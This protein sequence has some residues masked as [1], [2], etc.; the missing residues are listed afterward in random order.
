MNG[1][2]TTLGGIFGAALLALA[3]FSA[4]GCPGDDSKDNADGGM[5]SGGGLGSVLAKQ[6]GLTC[7]AAGKGVALGNASISGYAPIDGFFRSVVNYSSVSASVSADIDAELSGIQSLFA[8]TDAQLAASGSLGLAITAKL[9]TDFKASVVVNAQ[10]AQCSVDAHVAAEVT[11]KCQA[12]ANC[13]V[14]PGKATFQCM[15]TCNVDAS[16]S[17]SCSADA[18]VHCQVTSPSFTCSGQCSGSCT[19]MTPTVACGGTCRGTC[20][21]MCTGGGTAGTNVMGECTGTC[22]GTCTGGCEVTGMAAAMCKGSCSGTCDYDPG[23][24]MCDASAKVT[25]DLNATASASCTGR[26]SGD[27]QPPSAMCDASASCQA[28]AKAEAR[29]Q[30]HCTPPSVEVKVVSTGGVMAQAQVNFL[31]AELKA[32]LPR[33]SVASA[34]AKL[35]SDAAGDLSASGTAAVQTTANAV[36][37]GKLDFFVGAKVVA[38]VPAQLTEAQ[39]VLTASSAALKTRTDAAAAVAKSFGMVM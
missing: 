18:K 31:I 33:L 21:G 24:A 14:D 39:G 4:S 10:P 38:C 28:S 17:G 3:A 15:G 35:A 37:T 13:T 32:R 36:G 1:R 20:D 12:E 8:I 11:A 25:C 26:C 7:P 30:V 2:T 27:F 34:R 9:A 23:M 16:V 19:V 5:S 22:G 29:F 6:C